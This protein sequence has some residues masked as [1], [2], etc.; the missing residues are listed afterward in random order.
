[1]KNYGFWGSW[2]FETPPNKP[3]EAT[4]DKTHDLGR[5]EEKRDNG[6]EQ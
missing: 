2:V 3:R 1:M 4:I 6:H 5:V